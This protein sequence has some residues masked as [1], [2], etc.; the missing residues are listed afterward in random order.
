MKSIIKA[1]IFDLD[2]LLIDSEPIWNKADDLF[3]QGKYSQ[4][5]KEKIMGMG[6][7]EVIELFKKETGLEGDTDEL[8]EKRRKLLNSLLMND[9][10]L[11]AGAKN[12]L[13]TLK[14][15]KYAMAIAT[16]G[17]SKTKTEEILTKVG[18]RNYFSV[19][20]SGD[21]VK[22]G[23]P[24]PDIFLDA[25]KKLG[26]SPKVCL[27]LEDAL[28]GIEAAKA[29]EMMSYGVNSDEKIRKQLKEKGAYEVFSN[30][31]EIKL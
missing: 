24:F 13:E 26:V 17:Y 29:A 30:L 28:N 21:E 5:L 23:K 1:V 4:D 22:R 25:A 20:V 19:V 7:R 10:R 12:L 27:V 18:I 16:G 9:L 3:L 2:G 14:L 15:R 6:Q 11:F 8:L 31:L